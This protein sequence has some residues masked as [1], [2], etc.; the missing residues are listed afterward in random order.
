MKEQ[1]RDY[2]QDMKRPFTLRYN[3]LTQNIEVLDTKEKLVRYGV[4]I[5]SE[6]DRLITA[7]TKF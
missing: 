1:M 5:K 2:A 7:L 6:L 4:G 3:A